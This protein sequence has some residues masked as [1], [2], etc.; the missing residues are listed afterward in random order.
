MGDGYTEINYAMN[1]IFCSYLL[2]KTFKVLLYY[3]NGGLL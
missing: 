1:F 3:V 2:N